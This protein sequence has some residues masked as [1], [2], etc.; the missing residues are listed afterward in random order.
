MALDHGQAKTPASLPTP[1]QARVWYP[2]APHD[3]AAGPASYAYGLKVFHPTGLVTI[4]TFGGRAIMNAPSDMSSAPYPLVV[5][6]PGFALGSTSYAWLAEHLAS[7][8]FVVVSPEHAEL[9]DPAELWRSTIMRPRDIQTLTDVVA[10][11]TA[12]ET[13]ALKG[14]VDMRHTA[15]VGH[16]YGGYTALAA[17]GARLNATEFRD[18]CERLEGPDDPGTFLCDALIP[19]IQDMEAL[20]GIDAATDG[21]WPP[22]ANV[23]FDAA[24]SLAGDAAMF[25]PTGLAELTVPLMTI[26]GTADQDSP[27]RWST[28]FA[29][30]HS[31]SARKMEVGLEGAEHFVFTGP[32]QRVR[33]FMTITPTGFCSDP[34]WD[35]GEAHAVIAHYTTAFLRAE[36][37]GD[38]SAAADLTP[39]A[40]V[41]ANVTY[42]VAGGVVE[43]G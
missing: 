41:P 28:A 34:A 39:G 10:D 21:V 1:T 36:L 37:T 18:S 8:G 27:Y 24:I 23:R 25:G 5:L 16:S 9:L 32:C 7:H 43:P 6:S 4:A 30:D 40:A 20:A 26:G 35:R 3:T 29:Y 42:R 15:I 19:H 12:R 11:Q 2:A 13:G 33:L 14:L 31:S 22:L 17:A 38:D